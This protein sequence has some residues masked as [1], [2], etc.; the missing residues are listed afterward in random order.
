MVVVKKVEVVVMS[1]MDLMVGHVEVV[2]KVLVA[3]EKE[4]LEGWMEEDETV[5]AF[6]E[7]T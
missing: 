2:V 6:L 4:S 1:V 7:E 5:V 3:M